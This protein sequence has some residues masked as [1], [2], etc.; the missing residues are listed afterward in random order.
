M[1]VLI[2]ILI[3]LLVVGCGKNKTPKNITPL[4]V[5]DLPAYQKTKPDIKLGIGSAVINEGE[6]QASAKTKA[7]KKARLK[8]ILNLLGIQPGTG[9]ANT[10]G[11]ILTLGTAVVEKD[12]EIVMYVLVGKSDKPESAA[13]K[14]K[15]KLEN[16]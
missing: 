6:P 4:W 2:P 10:G 11:G 8:A 15:S 1:N 13:G 9:G 3:G 5:T 16:K 12:G 14:L 7:K